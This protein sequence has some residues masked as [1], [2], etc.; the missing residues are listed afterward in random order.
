MQ[1]VKAVISITFRFFMMHSWLIILSYLVAVGFFSGS[2]C[3]YHLTRVPYKNYVG[4]YSIAL[5][6]S[7][8]VSVVKYGFAGAAPKIT[9]RPF[10]RCAWRGGGYMARNL[11]H[12]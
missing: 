11:L 1:S 7:H 6:D 3:K 5:N 10:S 9:T 2:L 12:F 4:F 8:A